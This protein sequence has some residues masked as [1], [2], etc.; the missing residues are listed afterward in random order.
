MPKLY[1][2]TRTLPPVTFGDSSVFYCGVVMFYEFYTILYKV[3][4]DSEQHQSQEPE[5]EKE[6]EAE[7]SEDEEEVAGRAAAS[8]H[9]NPYAEFLAAITDSPEEEGAG[10]MGGLKSWLGFAGSMTGTAASV[11]GDSGPNKPWL[12]GDKV[13]AAVQVQ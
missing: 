4:Q 10:L 7:D 6:D 2:Q 13:T 3:S 8:R 5:T 12:R 1:T 11:L 9:P